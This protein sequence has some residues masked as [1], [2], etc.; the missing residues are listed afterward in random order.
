[1]S[2]SPGAAPTPVPTAVDF[3]FDPVCPWTWLTSRW[4]LD[5][6]Q[7]RA[8]TA[9]FHLPGPDGDPVAFFG[10]VV[11]PLPAAEAAGRLWDAIA[12]AASIPGF[13][14]LKTG[15]DRTPVLG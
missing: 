5:V 2:R 9:R 1:M 11:T 6:E 4:L 13:N 8:V 12:I 10:P 15:R 3:W 7:V 14:E